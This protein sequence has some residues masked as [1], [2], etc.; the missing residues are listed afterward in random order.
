MSV[1]RAAGQNPQAAA[2]V[3]C[4]S[5]ALG[6]VSL[7]QGPSQPAM[8]SAY[9][10]RDGDPGALDPEVTGPDLPSINDV[11]PPRNQDLVRP[12]GSVVPTPGV[13][14]LRTG[15]VRV[16]DLSSVI[17]RF[18]APG[19]DLNAEVEAF[20][21]EWAARRTEPH[22]LVMDGPLSD[23]ARADLAALGVDLFEYLPMN[24]WIVDV[25]AVTPMGV[26]TL[27][28]RDDVDALVAFDARW[29]IDPWLRRGAQARVWDS[30]ERKA[31][32][33]EDA[34]RGG[35][36]AIRAYAFANADPAAFVA[37]LNAVPGART[38]NV[39]RVLDTTT[40]ALS[41][42]ADALDQLAMVP[43]LQFAELVVEYGQRSNATT[44]WVVQ[45]NIQGVLPLHARGLTGTGQIVGF[46]DVGLAWE[47]C[48][49]WDQAYPI[50]PNHR[51]IVAYNAP[52]LYDLHGTHV[53]G[54]LLGDGGNA[55]NTRGIAFG[56]RIAFNNLPTFEEAS[57]AGRYELHRAQG[58]IIHS[59][60]WGADFF[61]DYDGG[62]RAID[63][64]SWTHDDSLIC[65]SVSNQSIL[66]NPEN[67]KNAITV[68]LTA[69]SPNQSTMPCGGASGPTLDGRRKPDV[70]A[71]GC[72]IASSA[73]ATTGGCGSTTRTGTSMAQPAVAALA[74]LTREYFLDGFYPSGAASA[75][76]GFTPSGALVK[77]VLA[78]TGQDITDFEGWPTPREG[79]G[80]VLADASL[81]FAGD[82]EDMIVEQAFNNGP[83]ALTQGGALEVPVR[84]EA[85][86]PLRVTL[87]WHDYPASILASFAPVNNLDLVAIAP[88]GSTYVGNALSG[89]NASV[90][91]AMRDPVN[92]IEMVALASPMA[93]V[94]RV[95]V[96]APAINVGAQG[97]GLV[98]VGKAERVATTN[99]R[100]DFDTDGGITG[101]DIEAFFFAF[102][103][104]EPNADFDQDGGVTGADIEAF[105]LAFESGC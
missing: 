42:P 9:Q 7:A 17:A 56:A 64:F 86:V 71:P 57:H 51:K 43:S 54:T 84:V 77:A 85:G 2:L 61:T 20:A 24:A 31:L 28:G 34:P 99:C 6:P 50:G 33:L 92:N 23:A 14:H 98:I 76:D 104:G 79:F 95:R 66:G 16:A 62:C 52:F 83:G 101:G 55:G 32:A 70:V 21:P 67:A 75:D 25:S 27:A 19:A 81:Y 88:D 96:E 59:N 30:P 12:A 36:L 22:V 15:D 26:A 47:H 11:V 10:T 102:E 93:G 44:R 18:R 82:P 69:N 1:L 89:F 46:M 90:A 103:A 65:F 4:A 45:S 100:A 97:F 13:L 60:S 58:A 74:V 37:A 78:S 91:N 68:S 87:A 72:L 35:R 94:W 3:L 8:G 63:A 40:V 38:T 48:S 41:L 29:K 5:A 105:F 73:G 39:T 80:R 49:F 53:A